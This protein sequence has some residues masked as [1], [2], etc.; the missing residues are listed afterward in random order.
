[1]GRDFIVEDRHY[2]AMHHYLHGEENVRGKWRAACWRAG[3][4]RPPKLG[5]KAMTFVEPRVRAGLLPG[6][7]PLI[8][9]GQHLGP[10][11][12]REGSSASE[13]ENELDAEMQAIL[14]RPEDALA[15]AHWDDLAPLARRYLARIAA[16]R[17]EASSG[18]VVALK[19][20]IG[21]A[22]GK[23]GQ[24]QHQDR[25]QGILVLPALVDQVRIPYIAVE[26]GEVFDFDG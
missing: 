6:N 21:R 23:V 3:F 11:A 25:P 18:Q 5:S 4:S 14:E 10:L 22:E 16:G 17:A 2:L 26:E 24:Q 12:V 13:P 7:R 1:M 9:D 15:S 8:I 20:I 19:E